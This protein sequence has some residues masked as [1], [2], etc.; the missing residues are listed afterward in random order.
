MVLS[1]LI[2][3]ASE[4]IEDLEP[5]FA[6]MMLPEG[7]RV[8][9][10]GM[11][12][13][14]RKAI[15]E[16]LGIQLPTVIYDAASQRMQNRARKTNIKIYK[17]HGE[18]PMIH[19]LGIPVDAAPWEL[20]YDIDVLQKTPLDMERCMLPTA[21][22]ERLISALVNPMSD[23]Y[24]E[25]MKTEDRVPAEIS[26]DP[27]KARNLSDEAKETVAETV[28]ERPLSE[29]GRRNPL[30]EQDKSRS[31]ELEAGGMMPVNTAYVPAGI[32]EI[33]SACP[34]VKEL[35]DERC[36]VHLT[37][38]LIPELT[39]HQETCLSIYKEIASA[40]LDRQVAFHH[41]RAAVDGNSCG[42][43]AVYRRADGSIGLNIRVK[44]LW[45]EPLGADALG[46]IVHECAHEAIEGHAIEFQREIQ[47]LAGK[48]A[49]WVGSNPAV[50]LDLQ[51]RLKK[52]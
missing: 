33:L 14:Q 47:R 9:F 48:L 8:V 51:E 18:R 32:K 16:V 5:Y 13:Q 50:W 7:V 28:F 22:K 4:G 10:N 41:F 40:L 6:S 38:G 20:P 42:I 45:N 25:F 44:H 2:R 30:D 11:I 34:T 43:Q 36:K 21:Y 49:V 26:N 17:K 12:V 1:A 31:Q 19:E 39:E 29:I 3:H 52:G 35:H 23:L 27:D 37:P 24:Q 46:V 15:R